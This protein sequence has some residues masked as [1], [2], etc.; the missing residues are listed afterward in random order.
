MKSYPRLGPTFLAVLLASS[1]LLAVDIPLTNWA[2]PPYQRSAASGGITTMTDITPG[3]GF[4]GITPCRLVDT[5]SGSGFP[6]GYGSPSLAAGA[7]RNFDL[8]S[9]PNCTGIPAGVEAYSLNFT[10][11]NVGGPGFLKVFPQGGAIPVDISTL[12]YIPGQNIANAAIVPAGTNGG[13]TVISG[14]SGTDLIIDINGYFTD[15]YNLDTR[16]LATG[17][18]AACAMV[19]G[20]NSN[21]TAGSHGVGG[22]A[23]GAGRVYGVQGQVGTGTAAASAG[24]RGIANQNAAIN[25]GGEFVNSS[26]TAFSAG[27][28]GNGNGGTGETYGVFG[29]NDS[30]TACAAGVHGRSGANPGCNF[31]FPIG[32]WGGSTNLYGVIGETTNVGGSAVRGY[33]SGTL[34]QGILGYAAGS[35]VH[36]LQNVTKVGAATFVEPDPRDASKQITYA[37][38]E[39]PEVGTYFRGRGKFE[40]GQA[41]VDVPEYFRIVTESEGL[42]IQVTPIG[43]MATVAV[44]RIDL[45]QIVIRGSRNVEFFYTVSGVRRGYKDFNPI[46]ENVLFVPEGAEVKM[47]RG[48]P[49]HV[50]KRLLDLGIY[51]A[52]HSPNMETAERLGW[53]QKWR[54]EVERVEREVAE[55]RA[56]RERAL[57]DGTAVEP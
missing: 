9:Q 40:R 26:T 8:N 54:G 52:D 2:V 36:S 56:A 25:Y 37:A 16:L 6:A 29:D 34:A 22:F 15:D 32:V 57:L 50:E 46:G 1:A 45:D 10:V 43:D 42:S 35:G 17:S 21:A 3:V 18:C 28:L 19:L 11:T 44:A 23:D 39:G 30:S 38:L 48:M 12:N 33:N 27:V 55:K 51:K 41:T 53:A 47:P 7:P 31:S 24:V 14:V 4:V 49:A 5:R 13:I 20:D